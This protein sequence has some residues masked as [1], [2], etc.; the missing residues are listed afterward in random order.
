MNKEKLREELA[1]KF[2]NQWKNWS[3][4]FLARIIEEVTKISGLDY[5]ELS[6]SQKYIS[7]KEADLFIAL[8]EKHMEEE[9]EK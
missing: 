7:R 8:I 2:H 1:E 4:Y 9:D 3:K 5:Y 6:E